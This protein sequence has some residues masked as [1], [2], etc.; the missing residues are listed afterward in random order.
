MTPHLFVEPQIASRARC[1]TSRAN[2]VEHR[3][4]IEPGEL[5]A[6]VVAPASLPVGD[7]ESLVVYVRDAEGRPVDRAKVSWRFS[8]RPLTFAPRA[9]GWV[10]GQQH[11]NRRALV[12]PGL[13]GKTASE[14]WHSV[15]I[16]PHAA[17]LSGPH[18]IDVT[19]TITAPDGRQQTLC[20]S[21]RVDPANRYVAMQR[22]PARPNEPLE[23]DLRLVEPNGRTSGVGDVRVTLVALDESGS[24]PAKPVGEPRHCSVRTLPLGRGRCVVVPPAPGRYRLTATYTHGKEQQSTTETEFQVG[25]ANEPLAE[26]VRLRAQNGRVLVESPIYPAS[27]L[28]T[29]RRGGLVEARVVDIDDGGFWLDLPAEARAPGFDVRVD[30]FG[31]SGR[32]AEGEIR[33]FLDPPDPI[34]VHVQRRHPFPNAP[35]PCCEITVTAL[36]PSG[37]VVGAETLLWIAEPTSPL[38]ALHPWPRSRVAIQYVDTTWPADPAEHPL[39]VL[40]NSAWAVHPGPVTGRGG[41]ARLRIPIPSTTIPGQC[42]RRGPVGPGG[43]GI[44]PSPSPVS[45][46]ARLLTLSARASLWQEASLASNTGRRGSPGP[47]SIYRCSSRISPRLCLPVSVATPSNA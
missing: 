44:D 23:V 1:A 14:G 19:L 13:D 16:R 4:R 45:T 41:V 5:R 37:A 40:A 35:G 7:E 11:G 28:V 26:V 29:V 36:G 21:L 17:D 3:L 31:R 22:G 18:Q 25:L 46:E 12:Q 6:M 32:R 9:A 10:I 30:V 33:I 38:R 20:R 47:C 2:T 43:L 15:S 34:R 8:S 24:G 42:G 27:G 39:P